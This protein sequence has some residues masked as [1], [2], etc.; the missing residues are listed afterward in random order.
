M[1]FRSQYYVVGMPGSFYGPL[2]PGASLDIVHSSYALQWLSRVPKRVVDKTSPAWNKGMIFYSSEGRETVVQAFAEQF[3]KDMDCFL[4][5][6]A[7]EVVSGGLMILII[8]GRSDET[9]HSQVDSNTTYNLLGS[10]LLDMANKVK[11]QGQ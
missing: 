6:R 11:N 7:K 9:P 2:F 4:H 1:L 8:L 3:A 10:C 5:F